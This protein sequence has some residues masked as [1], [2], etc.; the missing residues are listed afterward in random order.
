[1]AICEVFIVAMRLGSS[2]VTGAHE[3]T[4]V[5]C[6]SIVVVECLGSL[7]ANTTYGYI[8][9]EHGRPSLCLLLWRSHDEYGEKGLYGA[10][11]RGG[12]YHC[13]FA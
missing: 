2:A 9:A 5:L 7:A 4:S 3:A 10:T 8:H 6:S 13:N 11:S 12:G 1:M